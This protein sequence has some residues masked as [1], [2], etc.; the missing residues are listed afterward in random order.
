VA[1]ATKI[2]K[3]RLFVHSEMHKENKSENTAMRQSRTTGFRTKNKAKIGTTRLI[4]AAK[5]RMARTV[6]DIVVLE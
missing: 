6:L 2:S 5:V 4:T 1:I 3:L